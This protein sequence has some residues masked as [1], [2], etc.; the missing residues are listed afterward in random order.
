M[1]DVGFRVASAT[2]FPAGWHMPDRI[3]K[4]LT[5]LHSPVPLWES[6]LAKSVEQYVPLLPPTSLPSPSPEHV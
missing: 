6:K 1:T 2:L 4:S 5:H 3:G